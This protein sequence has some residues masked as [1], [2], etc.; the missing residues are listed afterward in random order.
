MHTRAIFFLAFL[1]E[2]ISC[3][4]LSGLASG[5]T[6]LVIRPYLE[7]DGKEVEPDAV[8][9]GRTASQITTTFRAPRDGTYSF[10][11]SLSTDELSLLDRGMTRRTCAS[12]SEPTVVRYPYDWTTRDTSGNIMSS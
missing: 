7:V 1:L 12:L 6:T 11:I 4:G 8:Q 9:M 2:L 5:A 3:A 10:G